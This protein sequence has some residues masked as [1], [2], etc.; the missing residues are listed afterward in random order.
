MSTPHEE[1]LRLCKNIAGDS[2]WA[3][4][5]S[6]DENHQLTWVVFCSDEKMLSKMPTKFK[7]WRVM[8]QYC[9]RPY[10]PSK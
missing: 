8:T 7:E 10:V 2:V 6:S 9:P 1:L 4:Q 3:L 5:M